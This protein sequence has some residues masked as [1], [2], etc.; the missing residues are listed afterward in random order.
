MPIL[1]EHMAREGEPR[2]F[3]GTLA[4]QKGFRIGCA[5]KSHIGASPVA[6]EVHGRIARIVRRAAGADSFSDVT[7]VNNQ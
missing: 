4:G 1:H 2:L 6:M 3:A 5:L 7:L